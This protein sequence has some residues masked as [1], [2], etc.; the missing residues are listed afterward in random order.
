MESF[1]N[2]D[3]VAVRCDPGD[4]L[5]ESVERALD[6][7]GVRDG[8]VVSGIGTL[9]N[10]HVYYLDTHDLDD[11]RAERD[12]HV[13]RDGCWEVTALSGLVADGE[14]HLHVTASEGERTLGGHLCPG[15]EVNALAEVLVE[16]T[17]LPLN[18]RRDA[19]GVAKLGR[20]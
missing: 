16:R 13:D 17:G 4:M 10:L 15:S 12:T 11:P 7:H 8:A 18:R 19:Q 6:D 1:A 3:Y 14:A 5:L 2:E 20:R 9:R